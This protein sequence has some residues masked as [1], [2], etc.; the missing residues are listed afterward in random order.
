MPVVFNLASWARHRSL[1]AW[2]VEELR[3]RYDI[4]V[5]VAQ[6]WVRAEQVVPL[7]DGLDEV[8]QEHRYGCV[9]AINSFRQKHGFLPLL[10]CSR[11]A[12]YL[13]LTARLRLHGAVQIQP[14]ARSQVTEYLR[15]AGRPLAGRDA[16]EP[17]A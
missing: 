12:D 13:E 5:G 14:L 16:Y 3:E 11:T 7:L 1:D 10:V 2:L 9:E 4:P 15:Q 8:K 17:V 6:R